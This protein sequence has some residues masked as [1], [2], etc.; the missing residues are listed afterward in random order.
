MVL[1]ETLI[2]A[3]SSLTVIKVSGIGHL[4]V[5]EYCSGDDDRND[6]DE[7][8]EWGDHLFAFGSDCSPL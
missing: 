3:A 2:A 7:K 8:V 1:A 6:C 5:V 4:Q